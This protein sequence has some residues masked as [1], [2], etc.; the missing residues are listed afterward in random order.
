MDDKRKLVYD[1]LVSST[2]YKDSFEEFNQLFDASDA[3][4][5]K[6]YDALGKTGYKDSFEEFVDLMQEQKPSKQDDV[7]VQA[8]T[9]AVPKNPA[10]FT[11]DAKVRD[12]V[13]ANK[14]DM[15]KSKSGNLATAPF[16]QGADTLEER[17]RVAEAAT[18]DPYLLNEQNKAEFDRVDDMIKAARSQRAAERQLKAKEVGG[19]GL[20]ST[21]SQAYVAGEQNETDRQL[22]YAS[23]LLDEARKVTAQADRSGKQN[24]FQ[25]FG[26]GF[27]DSPLDAW[28][29]GLQDLKNMSAANKVV[30]KVNSG[31][32]LTPSEEALMQAMVVNAASKMYND[33]KLGMGYNV[34]SIA[35]Q[36]LPFMLNMIVGM[37]AV[38]SVT[39]PASKALL[40]YATDKLTEM[41]VKGFGKAL[42][43]GA[44]RTVSGLGDVAFHTATFGAPLVAADYE[45]RQLGQTVTGVDA[46]GRPTYE[47]QEGQQTGAEAF[48]KAVVSTAAETGSELVGEY[49]GP[50]LGAVGRAL[51]VNKVGK[52]LPKSIGRTANE[53]VS[54][55]AFQEVK[56]FADAAK[57]TDPVGEYMEEVLNNLVSVGIGDMSMEQ[58]TDLDQNIETFLGVAPMSVLFG[59]AGAGNYVRQKYRIN[60]EMKN[61]ERKMSENYGEDWTEIRNALQNST[62]EEARNFVKDI[63]SRNDL[64]E[65]EKKDMVRYVYA[66]MQE[67]TLSSSDVVIDPEE[68]EANKREIFGAYQVASKRVPFL[69][70]EDKAKL[71]MMSVEEIESMDMPEDVKDRV[72]EYKAALEDYNR[73]IELTNKRIQ[74]AR[75]QAIAQVEELTNYST[76][77]VMRV[78][79]G[80]SDNP[81]HILRGK[82]TF[83][84]KGE[85]DASKSDKV[86]YYMSEDGSVKMGSTSMIQELIDETD[87][88][89]LAEQAAN[90]AQ[91]EIEAQETAETSP[92]EVDTTIQ[93]GD[94]SYYVQAKN[95][96][97]TYLVSVTTPQGEQIAQ[98][99]EQ[100]LQDLI[101]TQQAVQV[102]ETSQQTAESATT[103]QKAESTVQNRGADNMSNFEETL[104]RDD[105]GNFDFASFTPEQAYQYTAK[106]SGED[107]AREDLK[108]DINNLQAE[109]DKLT[110]QAKKAQGGKRIQI[111][112]QIADKTAQLNSMTELLNSV[113]TAETV[114][115]VVQE[116]TQQ[117]IAQAEVQA[118]P[119]AYEDMDSYDT[120]ADLNKD[121]SEEEVDAFVAN[122]IKEY[123]SQLGKVKAPKIGTD[124]AAY[125]EEKKAVESE[126]AEIQRKIDYWKGIQG[127]LS[128][129]RSQIGEK[130]AQ[131]I[132][133]QDEPQTA[134][135]Y[136][137]LK[138]GGGAIKL[139][140][141]SY[142]K[143]TGYG[144]EEAKK[145]F[146]LF[147]KDGVSIERAG[148]MLEEEAKEDG[149]NF[150]AEG[151]V[152]AGR[153]A[154]LNVLSEAR[155]RGDLINYIKNRRQAL[156]E[157]QMNAERAYYEDMIE[158]NF[159]MTA[160]EYEQYVEVAEREIGKRMLSDE[161]YNEFLGYFADET[162][163]ETED[164]RKETDIER[165]EAGGEVLQG[166]Q[167]DNAGG[168]TEVETEPTEVDGGGDNK[169][170]VAPEEIEPTPTQQA[171]HQA[172]SEVNTEPTEGQKEAGN[173][174]MGHVKIDGMD[175]TIENPKGSTRSGVDAN[176]KEWSVTMNNTYGYIRGTRG[177]DGD[178][179]DIFLS[180]NP[181]SGNVYVIDQ[182]DQQTGMY[183][184]SK[185]MYGF[186]S[187]DEARD[188]YLSNYEEGWKVGVITEVSKE[189]FKKWIESS[190]NKIKPFSEYVG[191]EKGQ[192]EDDG[193]AKDIEPVND[194]IQPKESVLDYAKRVAERE[195]KKSYGS[196][197]KVVTSDRY[198]E[199]KKRM[200]EKLSQLNV[201]FDPELLAIGTEMAAYHIE[202]GAR[203]FG[204]FASNMVADMGEKIIPYL[205]SFYNGARDMPGMEDYAGEMTSYE[206]V[207]AFNVFELSENKEEKHVEI[208]KEKKSVADYPLCNSYIPVDEKIIVNETF[209]SHKRILERV[210]KQLS[211]IP[212]IYENKSHTVHAHYFSSM[213]NIDM[214]VL[215]NENG[216]LYTYTIMNGDYIN[217]EF[218][219]SDIRE[220][221]GS[222]YMELD[223]YW[224]KKSLGDAL[225]EINPEYYKDF[226]REIEREESEE[227]K[228]EVIKDAKDIFVDKLI[229]LIGDE[230]L[231]IVSLRKIANESGLEADDILIQELTELAIINKA[232]AIVREGGLDKNTFDQI[233]KLYQNQPTISMRSSNRVEKQQYSTPI[234]ISF[235]TD[236]F[237]MKGSPNAILEPS[238]GNGMMVFA[239]PSD[240]VHVNDID[241]NRLNNLKKQGFASV[242][243]QDAL[244]PFNGVY[245]AIVTNPPFG[246]MEAKDYAGY[247]ISGLEKQ[248]SINALESMNDNGRAAIIIGGNTEYKENGSIKGAEKA[249]FNYL[250]NSYN[251]V[252][253]INISGD[254]YAKQGTKYPVRL[255]LIDGR[256]TIGDTRY[257]PIKSKARAEQVTTFDEL[258]NRVENETI[259]PIQQST[260]SDNV[261]E[262]EPTTG[263]SGATESQAV[264]TEQSITE[265]QSDR[266]SNRSTAG[267]R[268]SDTKKES[269]VTREGRAESNKGDNAVG[270]D[271]DV[272][273][274]S[275]RTEARES[276]SR[277]SERDTTGGTDSARVSETP[278]N[279]DRKPVEINIENEK[280]HYPAQSRAT[281]I[282]SVVPTNTVQAIEDVLG[283]FEDIDAYVQEKLGYDTKDELFKALSAEQI[284]SVALAI[285]QMEKGQGFIIGDMTGVGKGRQ[286]AALIRYA[287]RSGHKP[288]FMTEK[289][290]LFSDI[291]RDLRDIGSPELVPFIVNDKGDSDPSMTDEAGN[292]IY[293]VP[294]KGVKQKAYGEKEVPE[295][296]DYVVITYSQ[297]NTSDKKPSPKKDFFEEIAKDNIVIMDESHNAGGTGNTGTFLQ[298]VIPTTSG[299]TFLSGTFAKRADNMP[300]YAIKTN[301]SDANMS[302]D[303]LI[304][305]IMTGGVPLQEIMSRNLVESGQMIRRE[306]DY[307]GV[308]IDWLPMEGDVER[309]KDAFN[310]VIE[311]FNDLI[312]FQRDYIDPIIDGMSEE[313]AEIQGEAGHTKG[314]RDLGISNT[315]FASKTFNLVRQLLFALKAEYVADRAVMYAKDGLKPVIAV[316]N[317]MEG[318]IKE[319]MDADE[320]VENPDFSITLRKGLDGLFRYTEKRGNGVSVKKTI[321]LSDISAEGQKKYR[322]LARKIEQASSG[323]SISPID[324]IKNK[325]QRAGFSIGELTGREFELQYN[326]DGTVR[327]VKR[328]DK[329]KKKLMRDFNNGSLD[330][331]ILN[332]S[333]STG[334]SLHAST[335]F[336]DQRQRVMIF[337]QNQLD[338]NTEVQM[339]GRTDRTG[340]VHRSKYEYIV[341][342]IPAEGRLM[343]MFKSKLKSL[344]ANTTSSQKSKINEMQ[345]VDFLNKYG[346]QVV[347][348]YLKENPELADKL[349][350][351]LHMADMKEEDIEKMKANGG[352]AT[353]V[354]GRVALLNVDEQE[355]F[356]KDI[357]ERYNTL[358]NYLNETGT[359]D[360]E[361]TTV[362]LN[363]KT[364]S[365]EVIVPGKDP[366]SGNAFADNSYLEQV[367]VDVLKKPM[368]ANEIKENINRFTEGKNAREYRDYLIDKVEEYQSTQLAKIREEHAKNT[369]PKMEEALAKDAE[370]VRKSKKIEES[371]KE[372]T[373]ASRAEGIR[374]RYRAQLERKERSLKYKMDMF[375]Q[376]FA[377]IPVGRTLL[378][379][380]SLNTSDAS[381][382]SYGMLMGY[383]MSDKMSPSTTTAVFATLD[384]RRK[385]EIPLSRSE[386]IQSIISQT[387]MNISSAN[388]INLSNWDE[389]IPNRTRKNAYIITGNVL[390]AYGTTSGGQLV[391][392]STENGEFK[393][394]IL[395]PDSFKKSDVRRREPITTKYDD[396]I[397]GEM[398]TDSLNEVQFSKAYGTIYI[399]VPQS[400]RIG[401]K[402]Y[403]DKN[404]Q[405][406]VVNG[407]FTQ[408]GNKF[409]AEVPEANLKKMLEYMSDTFGTSVNVQ[410]FN[411]DVRFRFIGEQGAANLDRA[412]EATTR[413]DNLNVA[414]EMEQADKDAKAIKMAT[415][416]ERGADGKWRYE[417]EDGNSIFSEDV[418][419]VD[420]VGETREIKD[421]MA[422]LQ[423][424]IRLARKNRDYD[425]QDSLFEE[426][427]K[428][429]HRLANLRGIDFI[430][431][432]LPLG[433]ESTNMTLRN[434]LDYDNY[435]RLTDA[436]PSLADMKVVMIASSELGGISG[437]YNKEKNEIVLSVYE[438]ANLH[439]TLMHEI[440]HAIQYK[441]GFAVGSSPRYFNYNQ[442]LLYNNR[443]IEELLNQKYEEIRSFP[444]S[445]EYSK[446]SFEEVNQFIDR[447]MRDN[448]TLEEAEIKYKDEVDKALQDK[449]PSYKAHKEK[450][451]EI[452]RNIEEE[453]SKP[454]T[455]A[456]GYQ[457]TSGEVEARNVQSRLG[458][459]PEQRRSTLASETEDVAREDQIFIYDSMGA[460][461]M[462]IDANDTATKLGVP[463]TVHDALDSVP[464]GPAKEAIKK[465]RKVK[466]WY[467]TKTGTVHVYMPN[468]TSA[469]DVQKTILHEGVAHYGLRQLVGEEYFD[470]F[471]DEVFANV[472]QEVRGRIVS[473]L[474]KYGY[475]SRVATEEYMATLAENG[476]EPSVW[477]R[478]KQ[479]FKELLRKVGIKVD[480]S[481]NE[482]KYILWRSAQNLRMNNP[483]DLAKDVAMQYNM[484]VGNYLREDT[485]FTEEEQSIIDEAKKNGT[486]MKAPNGNPTNLTEKQWAQVRTQAFK[487]W[488]GDWE[489]SPET[490]SKVVDENG[491]PK[492]VYHGTYEEFNAFEE[493]VSINAFE[494]MPSNG[495]MFS[496]EEMAASVY[497][498]V[499]EVFLNIK[500]INDYRDKNMLLDVV[501]EYYNDFNNSTDEFYFDT[502]EDAKE[503]YSKVID[504]DG[505]LYSQDGG[506]REAETMWHVLQNKLKDVSETNG[507]DGFI[508]NDSSRGEE[509]ISYCAFY[510]EQIKSA[511]DN[512]GSFDPTD[513]DI[514]FREGDAIE[515]YNQSFNKRVYWFKE[516]W[517][518]S[519]LAL[520][521]LQD[522]VAESSGEP[523]KDFENAYMAENQ[524]SRL[525]KAQSIKFW[526][527]YM[528][529]LANEVAKM[530]SKDV[531]YQDIIDYLMLSHGIERNVEMSNRE[532]INDMDE[533]DREAAYEQFYDDVKALRRQYK[534]YDYL[535]A[536]TDYFGKVGDYSA[537]KA[538]LSRDGKKHTK[539]QE[540]ALEKVRLFESKNKVANL[541]N[542]VKAATDQS[543]RKTFESGMMG[544][545]EYNRVKDMFAY[546]V[547]LRGWE[548]TKAEDVYDYM[549]DMNPVNSTLKKMK[550]RKT[551][552]DDPIATIGNMGESAIVQGNRNAMKQKFYN[553]AV[554]H[555]TDLITMTKA[556]YA[557]NANGD[558]ELSLPQIDET[559][560]AET[561][562]QKIKDHDEL[563]KSIGATRKK[564]GLNISYPITSS[565][566]TQHAVIVKIGGKDYVLYIN[567]NPRA[568]QAV[569]GLTNPDAETNRVVKGMYWINRQLSALAT[570]R[571][572]E[573]VIPNF[574]RDYIEAGIVISAKEDSDYNKAFRKNMRTA[575]VDVAKGFKGKLKGDAN[576]YFTEFTENGGQMGYF[577]ISDVNAYKKKLKKQMDEITG[578]RGSARKALSYIGE[579]IEAVNKYAETVS[580][581]A[582][583]RTSREMGRSIEQS[584]KDASDVTVNF[585]KKGSGFKAM[586]G[587]IVKGD[588][589]TFIPKAAGLA[590]GSA[591]MFYMFI[592]PAIQSLANWGYITKRNKKAIIGIAGGFALAG[593]VIPMIN[594]VLWSLFGDDD[595]ENPYNDLPEWIR[596]NCLCIGVGYYLTIPLPHTL[597]AFYGMGEMAYNISTG[598]KDMTPA[599]ITYEV[600]GQITALLPI[601]PLGNDGDLKKTLTPSQIR[602]VAEA[603]IWNEDFMGTPIAKI[604]PYNEN[605]PEWKRVYKGT[606]GWLVD[607]SKFFND[608]SAGKEAGRDF[609]K[610]IIDFNPAKLE[611]VG[612]V[613]L[614]GPWKFLNNA[615]KTIY[616]TGESLIEGE[617]SDDLVLSN[618]PILRRFLATPDERTSFSGLN[619]RYYDLV[620]EMEQFKYE[621][622]GVK[623]SI[624]DDPEKY[625]W[626]Y[627]ELMKSDDY[628]KYK[629]YEGYR[630]A[631]DN[632][633]K[634]SKSV[635]DEEKKQIE[636]Y[637]NGLKRQ[638]LEELK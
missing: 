543:L 228:E 605:D 626:Q 400:K 444:D 469:E 220:I 291:Y 402:Y 182:V 90:D 428:L 319:E 232:K 629:V 638:L 91:A 34:G 458:M 305:A 256:K 477:N 627:E 153:A 196:S 163:N 411:D 566:K 369:L 609:R 132:L 522:V 372:I 424:E 395:L 143:E 442:T 44:A 473:N 352:E 285:S 582:T 383:K 485:D 382:F 476:V 344:D 585:S 9:P 186:G 195:E 507:Y 613:Y 39:K 190:T 390:Q 416:W 103:T 453:T 388:E 333:A 119:T 338:V 544:R 239:I 240:I 189:E 11:M 590:A 625:T 462:S 490:A 598:K 317:T 323:L 374:D 146:G 586:G 128:E 59:G 238:A 499:K 596:R 584:I 366:E 289:A 361:I 496:D 118:E 1:K 549:G 551:I 436:Y 363:A 234:P 572:P 342:P 608:L 105:K 224:R 233:V 150:F 461:S 529:P 137:A 348:D 636:D 100:Q 93:S 386:S 457:R 154:V 437:A 264:N 409:K 534:G 354:A 563:M 49:F 353:K 410:A 536:L 271:S 139:N 68:I 420:V 419:N 74:R 8:P 99:T 309:Q 513:P 123:E 20:F 601:D 286:A 618:I 487:D 432:S 396:I 341:S 560:N 41:G 526:D 535:K 497:G 514:R 470:D 478:I 134:E 40:K 623:R 568:A 380:N 53:I 417:Q 26:Q 375:K 209:A 252:D 57:I 505:R 122:N 637:S 253:V 73:Y 540:D 591:K 439:P 379:P 206:E 269:S 170:N 130:E 29:L 571:N 394:G 488:F 588:I 296:Y 472:S 216:I 237:V 373:I 362:P 587:K 17:Y 520:K 60:K 498:E 260:I 614:G 200:R 293:K 401:G 54:S 330:M 595:R 10:P 449:F 556:W 564:Q 435:N 191:I 138:L 28:T 38:Q 495:Y 399:Y 116:E 194:G 480:I 530:V 345:I 484:G 343:M 175:I 208:P 301:M 2:G 187:M 562:A 594:Q 162:L 148:E 241:E 76:G 87:A 518:D 545:D 16:N 23:T 306:R 158:R 377:G 510:P 412:E 283:K 115:E 211:E 281:E 479:A 433:A 542:L 578:R 178:H 32:S 92:V 515:A 22:E 336:S 243:S 350:D 278:G 430:T 135:E 398:V 446:I 183:D 219:Y 359:N 230:K 630:N 50:M 80:F 349:L 455:G 593:Y 548:G 202:A 501:G 418:R 565:S 160:E 466:G 275:G 364:I 624:K 612:E 427:Q 277:T 19:S 619:E 550:G 575:L 270:M 102:D 604:T 360:L 201:G 120:L 580:R 173:Y 133:S 358:I 502:P 94:T 259:L 434:I 52:I 334:I 355:Q 471:L 468:A 576:K 425:L 69:T 12:Y 166:E 61:F 210:E 635:S 124:K 273:G 84:D 266:G 599:E 180:D 274:E 109:I 300:I 147:S 215:E 263:R 290:N 179:I 121:L 519:M 70:D 267:K 421:R 144:N 617:K 248:M 131:E 55:P 448:I 242:S 106:M 31:S 157:K 440:Q 205:K 297:L 159:N 541:R 223:L 257:A 295:G 268:V 250:Y 451:N 227:V 531:S 392:Y 422:D 111:R 298:K 331:L 5:R 108:A 141:E 85:V 155:T 523:I 579:A 376:I 152:N 603:Y 552:P 174:K 303:E 589:S 381:G 393:Q 104:P 46:S 567:G 36:S 315:P 18:K 506:I 58:F 71:P 414:R 272:I 64:S 287:V 445:E 483:L 172:E 569:N 313:L 357:S 86:I 3:N 164:G 45:R 312:H 4:K 193:T 89:A 611:H 324:V 521:N 503:E 81:V 235:L 43:R 423:E 482:L 97:G 114:Q 378:I 615:G 600:A 368:T 634:I 592:N 311:I 21:L 547:P 110:E 610:G 82:V 78:K 79:S 539:F 125:L 509:H 244:Q 217:A 67:Q 384:G 145:M 438:N 405:K 443:R 258:F 622:D 15:F 337:A 351:P 516:A 621:L 282:G 546:Y 65:A 429:R 66:N 255:I 581:Y 326:D 214:F 553:M 460:N 107:V 459:T 316:S 475:N 524:L 280:T 407:V 279:V 397:N 570:S 276:Q 500:K 404:M 606:A 204:E 391:T 126:K 98:M 456:S 631:L 176:G 42:G 27:T 30:D 307:T 322:E 447:A 481:D 327:K 299:V 537:T 231:N 198:E 6:V 288:I 149:Y 292:V 167:P 83:N 607:T 328:A 251:V 489:N 284:D 13:L 577:S 129:M 246:S 389:K 340:Q 142:L 633:Y 35:A 314:T 554:N 486:Y 574:V 474:P 177:V 628:K 347:V 265:P 508:I 532:R 14:P 226:G 454:H 557:P 406:F 632:L 247:K 308:T 151:D 561:I 538:I 527:E 88:S 249:F 225:R 365:R 236:M 221:T 555:P 616:Y 511:T 517:Q 156:A 494:E 136:A 371:E 37:G 62:I 493:G 504:P 335:R 450:L 408:S 51:G 465:G 213:G 101:T 197:N 321:P 403:L 113:T 171:I 7:S 199:L 528:Q 302:Q 559:D 452:E 304:E 310:K 492:V 48:G 318:F 491:E 525:N 112:Q 370:K 426:D 261:G 203:K 441:E 512:T 168:S 602:G 431:S 77:T 415:G 245:D 294:S 254:L 185:V 212:A 320:D 161:D 325:V 533:Q 218:G 573:F 63:L 140:R 367:E 24:F 96:D 597:R 188:A 413:L 33:E 47:G 127:E 56:K 346:D 329:D 75:E 117:D 72:I 339:R 356:Y 385:M 207:K 464:E 558:M 583:Y 222:P 169:G 229:N 165:S 181:E 262:S 463:I 387:M 95:P 192:T 25:N 184:E 620:D 332:Q 467:D